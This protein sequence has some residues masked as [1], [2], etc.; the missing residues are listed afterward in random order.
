MKFRIY[1]K[2]QIPKGTAQQK[3]YDGRHNRFYMTP[4]CIRAGDLFMHE[5]RPFIPAKPLSGALK[6]KVDFCY[7]TK[8]KKK[9]GFPKTSVPDCD[10]LVKLFLDCMTRV[11]F[12]EDDSQITDLRVLKWWAEEDAYIEVELSELEL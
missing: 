6:L 1:F 8:D 9:K 3:R 4:D 5:L 10:N 12:W 11:G 7:F 2:D